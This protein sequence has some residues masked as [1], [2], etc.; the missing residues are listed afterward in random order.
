M[1]TPERITVAPSQATQSTPLA[2]SSRECT[3]EPEISP[4][5]TGKGFVFLSN[6]RN[7]RR[8]LYDPDATLLRDKTIPLEPNP[9]TSAVWRGREGDTHKFINDGII[10]A[11]INMENVVAVTEDGR[12]AK[13]KHSVVSQNI[14]RRTIRNAESIGMKVNERKTNQICISDAQSFKAR[15]HIYSIGGPG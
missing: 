12:P 13:S 4:T 15:A 9:P 2:E 10:D 1:D 11:K 7:V 5:R 8:N 14:F 3:F 6:A